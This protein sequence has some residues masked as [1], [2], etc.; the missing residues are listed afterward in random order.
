[1]NKQA[2]TSYKPMPVMENVTPEIFRNTILPAHNPVLL[3]GY[4]S[5]W[6]AVQAAQRSIDDIA[7]YLKSFDQGRQTDVIYGAPEIKGKFFFNEEVSGLNF[8]RKPERI[9]TAID[10]LYEHRNTDIPASIYIQ[11]V[12]A[13]EFLPG[14]ASE[15]VLNLVDASISP[16]VWIGNKL[17]VQTHSDLKENIACVVAGNRRFTLFPP[18]QLPNLY[19][20]PFERTLSG[21]PV[22]MVQ[23]EDVDYEKYPRFK[24]AEAHALV[25]DLEAGDAIY[26]PYHWWHHVQS[27]TPFNVLVNFWWNDAHPDL[28][29]PFDCLLHGLLSLRDLP[30]EQRDTWRM[31]FDH[32]VFKGN[33]D[34]AEHLAP[35]IRGALGTHSPQK[36]QEMRMMLLNALAHQAG[37]VGPPK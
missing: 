29:S 14:F 4:V 13:E 11:S 36:R 7:T 30:K 8:L 19:V 26:I 32:Y 24:E 25:A 18:D 2:Q 1:M 20:G 5:H 10:Q 16:R 33:G 6:P 31:V 37:V 12:V 34:P 28:G 27:L 21:P 17:T 35:D 3:K 9:S 23:L 22:S 15:H